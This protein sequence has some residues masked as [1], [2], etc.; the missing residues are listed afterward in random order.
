MTM[1]LQA[2]IRIF[3]QMFV[4]IS[5]T[6]HIVYVNAVGNRTSIEITV[7][8]Q[9]SGV[10]ILISFAYYHCCQSEGWRALI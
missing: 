9:R 8:L 1:Q 2:I 6:V 4:C 10:D 7:L 3:P 5:E